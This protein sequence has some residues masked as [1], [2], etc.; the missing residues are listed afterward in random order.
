M[1]ALALGNLHACALVTTATPGR[2]TPYCWGQ[3]SIGQL[4]TGVVGNASVAGPM[5]L[6]AGSGE[7]ADATGFALSQS[8]T[9]VLRATGAGGDSELW[10]TGSRG[11]GQLGDG[12]ITGSVSFLQ[13]IVGL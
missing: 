8:A 1:A 13:R 3:G 10:C 11:G 6:S 2:F 4:G 12:S 9:C 5:L 7:V